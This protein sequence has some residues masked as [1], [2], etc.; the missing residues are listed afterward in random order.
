MEWLLR[1]GANVDILD[2]VS[3]LHH[4]SA[5]IILT[6]KPINPNPNLTR[7]YKVET[8]LCMHVN[9]CECDTNHKPLLTTP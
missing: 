9:A 5:Q 6:S 4:H 3:A 8:E 2:H 7:F 1:E